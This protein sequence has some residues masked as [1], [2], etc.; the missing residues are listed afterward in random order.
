MMYGS[1]VVMYGS[2]VDAGKM[3][4]GGEEDGVTAQEGVGCEGEG[5]T[6]PQD[7]QVKVY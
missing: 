7:K 5:L 1:L 3:L 4:D 2:L 6:H